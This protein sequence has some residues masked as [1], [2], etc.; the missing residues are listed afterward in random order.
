VVDDD[1]D[2]RLGRELVVDAWS[3]VVDQGES[4][5]LREVRLV[6]EVAEV[7]LQQV[8]ERPVLLMGNLAVVADV[9]VAADGLG[10]AGERDGAGDG[11]GVRIVVGHDRQ[12]AVDVA[13]HPLELA[14]LQPAVSD[15][16][17]QLLCD[18]AAGVDDFVGDGRERPLPVSGV[19]SR[20]AYASTIESGEHRGDRPG[21]PEVGLAVLGGNQHRIRIDGQFAERLPVA[22]VARNDSDPV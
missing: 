19:G 11:V 13:Q 12:S 1:V 2:L 8:H 4:V 15:G 16:V 22:R 17:T 14:D 9:G 10:D 3:G 6:V 21:G 7:E 5:V 18:G 20:P